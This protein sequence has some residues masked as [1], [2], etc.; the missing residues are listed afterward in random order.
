MNV[1]RRITS[2]NS[3]S[4]SEHRWVTRKNVSLIWHFCSKINTEKLEK[5]YFRA[6]KFIYQDFNSSYE[7]LLDIAGSTTQHLSRL[8]SLA[9][10]TFKSEYGMSPSYLSDFVALKIL[11][12]ISGIQIY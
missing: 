1:I 8:R 11:R 10:Q 6:L 3:D 7:T 9:I 2:K 4:D 12:T 5:V